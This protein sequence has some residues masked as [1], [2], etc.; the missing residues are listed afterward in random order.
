LFFINL[1]LQAHVNAVPVFV[2][3]KTRAECIY[4]TLSSTLVLILSYCS[5]AICGYLSFG[6]KV[7]HDILVS[8]E[9][10]SMS[11]SID[12]ADVVRSK[13]DLSIDRGDHGG[14][15]NIHGL[16]SESVL[17]PVEPYVSWQKQNDLF[18]DVFTFS[19]AIDSFFSAE[20]RRSVV[21]RVL[22]VCFWF[23]STL[24]GAVFLPNISLAIHYLGALAASFIFIFP[25]EE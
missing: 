20:A 4:A 25:G 3:L 22:I 9:H 11:C 14:I 2:S 17:W 13:S 10:R 12:L 23:F 18:N 15:E 7:E 16:S 5:V 24:I 21:R 1:H 6:I 8:I 19:T